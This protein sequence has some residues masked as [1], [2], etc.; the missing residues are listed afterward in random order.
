MT[1]TAIM[2]AILNTQIPSPRTWS[3]DIPVE[4]ERITMKALAHNRD[5]RYD[6]AAA[7][8]A[9]LEALLATMGGAVSNRA[10]GRFVSS[11][12]ED[13]RAKIKAL[14]ERQLAGQKATDAKSLDEWMVPPATMTPSG[15][16]GANT[17]DAG[18]EEP[19]AKHRFWP[20]MAFGVASAVALLIALSQQRQRPIDVPPPVLTET[21][22]RS[23][24]SA[25]IERPPA[26]VT[27]RI[28]AS[29]AV[30]SL[31]LDDVL[32]D[33][34]PYVT[35]IA[36]DPKA[37]T[38]RAEAPGYTS[39]TRELTLL[40][41]TEISIAL[42]RAVTAAPRSRA[43]LRPTTTQP[44]TEAPASSAQQEH[45]PDCDPPYVILESGIRRYK[46]ECL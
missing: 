28:R 19:R 14:I 9:D 2:H 22:S 32:L 24:E 42:E 45:K 13:V 36:A 15:N 6:T 41:D 43:K 11:Q 17:S 26:M 34:N 38:L 20:W 16:E 39:D 10:I 35:H 29:P 30:A 33:Q 18:V 25:P 46:A 3:P 27:V 44:R 21:P 40:Q 4:L 1:D 31:Y 5:H 12:F 23:A 37:R 8:Q 7:L